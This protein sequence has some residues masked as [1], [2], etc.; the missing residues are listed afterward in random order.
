MASFVRN[1]PLNNGG[2]TFRVD[3]PVNISCPIRIA[4]LGAGK[5]G[6]T[7]IV[8]KLVQGIYTDTYYPTVRTNSNMFTF[9][10]NSLTSQLVLQSKGDLYKLNLS[11]NEVVLSSLL[12]SMRKPSISRRGR[13]ASDTVGTEIV[14]HE[15]ND[16]FKTYNYKSDLGDHEPSHITPILVEL[17]D[18]P[19][20]RANYIPFLESSLYTDLGKDVLKNLAN[21]PRRDVLTMPLLVASGAGELNGAIDGY[22]YVYSAIP[23]YNPP[24]YENSVNNDAS[25]ATS[26][27]EDSLSTLHRIKSSIDEAWKEFYTFK[28]TWEEGKETDIYSFKDSLKNFLT[29][30]NPDTEESKRQSKRKFY[31]HLFDNPSDPSDPNS[32]PPIWIICTHCKSPLKSPKLIE[33][34]KKMAKKCKSGFIAIDIT[35]DSVE[36]TLALM[37]KEITIRRKL[38]KHE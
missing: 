8:S 5:T 17:I 35:D 36:D 34:G 10:P 18:T 4:L 16:I 6:K 3:V 29:N 37:I 15:K 19:A 38:R 20:Y 7:S 2:E 22:F 11:D 27:D 32:P 25:S 28:R 13:A 33:G 24:A 26:N 9:Y 12:Q 21:E 1:N 14:I 30:K 31:T 23:S